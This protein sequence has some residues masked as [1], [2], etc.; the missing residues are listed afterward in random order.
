MLMDLA[1]QIETEVKQLGFPPERKPFSPHL[2]LARIKKN[3]QIVGGAMEKA[4]ILDDPYIFGCLLVEK[5]TLFRSELRPTGSV[6]TK[7]WTVSLA[8]S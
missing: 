8:G 7:L 5:V 3:Q 4:N 1:K 6:Y 2:T